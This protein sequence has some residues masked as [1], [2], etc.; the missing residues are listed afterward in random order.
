MAS[1]YRIKTEK[2]C[3]DFPGS[4]ETARQLAESMS[5]ES[6][7]TLEFMV[8]DKL[9]ASWIYDRGRQVTTETEARTYK[10]Y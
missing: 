1:F 8:R 6:R 2:R 9:F 5:L 3:F 4:E 10:T 7:T